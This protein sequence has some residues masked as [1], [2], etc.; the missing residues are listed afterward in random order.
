M[1]MRRGRDE[2][3]DVGGVAELAALADGSIAPDRRAA[4]EAKIAA[5]PALADRLAEQERAVALLRGAGEAVDAPE[6]GRAHV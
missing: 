5:S 4:L 6:I 2:K 3:A 1:R